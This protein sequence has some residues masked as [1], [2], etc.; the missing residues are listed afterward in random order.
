MSEVLLLVEQ[1]ENRRLLQ[2]WLGQLPD[3]V[4]L[5]GA[6]PER[7][8]GPDLVIVDGAGL[9]QA[10]EAITAL[11]EAARPVQVPC[12]LLVDRRGLAHLT[13]ELSTTV[14]EILTIPIQKVEL[15]ARIRSLLRVRESSLRAAED[16]DRRYR[17]LF[18]S[19]PVGLFTAD[20]REARILEA[21]PALRRMLTVD[22]SAPIGT[23][24]TELC[25]DHA[26][27]PRLASALGGSEPVEQFEFEAWR[28]DGQRLWLS[29]SAQRTVDPFD[30]VERI[31]GSIRDVTVRMAYEREHH[32]RAAQQAAVARLGR[33]AIANP[34]IERLL[35]EAVR[36]V[37][38]SL[39][40]D[41]AEVVQITASTGHGEVRAV[42]GALEASTLEDGRASH[43][44]IGFAL[45]STSPLIVADHE[46]ETRFPL[47]E[48]TRRA[49]FRSSVSAVIEGRDAPFGVLVAYSMGPRSFRNDEVNFVVIVATMLAEAEKRAQ[50]QAEL[51]H[52]AL[53]D[54]LTGLP[55]R[56]LALDRL[57]HALDRLS[58]H[59]SHG[60]GVLYLDVDRFKQINDTFG[61]AA[62]DAFLKVFAARIRD[63][64]RPGDTLA[65]FGGDELVIVCEELDGEQDA[66]QI[67]ERIDEVIQPAF[68]LEG[69]DVAVSVSVGIALA[70]DH[71]IDGET[72]LRE[73]DAALYDA[74]ERGRGR[75]AIFSESL[76]ELSVRRVENESALR[77]ALERGEL[78]LLYQPIV[79]LADGRVRSVEALVRWRHPDQGMLSPGAFIE[80]AQESGLIVPIGEWVL[81][82]ACGQ[83][84]RW[85]RSPSAADLKVTVNLSARQLSHPDV[86]ATVEEAIRQSEL[87]P[88]RLTLEI[89]EETLMEAP[90]AHA[91]ALEHL[92]N[93][94]VG[95]SIDDFGV[96]RSS[97]TYL[98]R[99]PVDALKLDRSLVHRLGQC[100]DDTAIVTAIVQMA[101]ALRLRVIAEGVETV[102]QAATLRELRADSAQGHHFFRPV[103]AA[104]IPQLCELLHSAA[105]G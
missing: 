104:E 42:A 13:A 27:C 62:G 51:R 59:P 64:I 36:E 29:V 71:G 83:A 66:V 77:V 100:G 78:T 65:R 72:I 101:H 10:T 60:V 85:A 28:S 68:T 34:D 24:L 52:R 79:E 69:H 87:D 37:A 30:K 26:D 35:D 95:L 98:R 4:V 76:R 89:A 48:R 61:H 75:H 80:I 58:R 49:G 16:A 5:D 20:T 96:G 84:A 32:R 46:S 88:R 99:L 55:N 40:V 53:H 45:S 22:G 33:L 102:A 43:G 56:A 91:S 15:D 2:A 90:E 1:P 39:A 23:K 8:F 31:T 9:A 86:A 18:D 97:L 54:V 50:T 6:A 93:L 94:E 38:E 17:E 41:A 74:K 67:A 14:D 63:A 92:R 103:E 44:A 70:W 7:R 82:E 73:A 11:R 81:A 21:N 105:H 57:N 12:L 25:V 3:V 19:A 47:D